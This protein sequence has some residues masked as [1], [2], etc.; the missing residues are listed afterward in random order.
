MRLTR[1][2]E[3]RATN[4]LLAMLAKDK[5]SGGNGLRTSEMQG[6]RAFHGTH[7]LSLRQIARLLRKAG[8]ATAGLC[9]SGP[10]TYN[11]WTLTDKAW[12]Q[13]RNKR[14]EFIAP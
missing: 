2:Q 7:T 3:V 10:Y 1:E 6:S 13:V 5:Q 8:K 14:G 11:Q 4:E 12:D 9:G